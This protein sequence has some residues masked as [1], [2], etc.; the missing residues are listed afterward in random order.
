MPESVT[1]QL[2]LQEALR[3]EYGICLCHAMSHPDLEGDSLSREVFVYIS[4]RVLGSLFPSRHGSG[5][6]EPAEHGGCLLNKHAFLH[7][8][9]MMAWDRVL[10]KALSVKSPV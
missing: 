10:R 5:V 2:A 3:Q 6:F 9:T 1:W 7:N 4:Y 8:I